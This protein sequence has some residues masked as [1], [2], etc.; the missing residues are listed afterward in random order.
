MPRDTV[1]QNQAFIGFRPVA[2]AKFIVHI[3]KGGIDFL[4]PGHALGQLL[5]AEGNQHTEDDDSDFTRKCAPTV[6]RFGYMDVHPVAPHDKK[7]RNRRGYVRNG[8]R[9]DASGF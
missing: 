3:C 1:M 4:A 6:Q 2:R 5:P 8:C 7:E 9:A